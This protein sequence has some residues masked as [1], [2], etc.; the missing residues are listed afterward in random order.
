MDSIAQTTQ[1]FKS[2]ADLPNEYY[3]HR[4]FYKSIRG[5][6][7]CHKCGNKGLKFRSNYEYC[8]SC[9]HKSSVKADSI[10]KGSNLSFK[11]IYLLIWCWQRK[12]GIQEAI[13]TI[14][15]SY[16]TIERWY[17]RLREALPESDIVLEDIVEIRW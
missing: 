13:S 9:R 12:F 6:A 15:I 16:P 7:C 1:T 4:N 5:D 17:D 14:G 2:I 8:P 10:F 11:K 3:C